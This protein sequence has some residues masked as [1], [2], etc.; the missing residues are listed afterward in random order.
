MGSLL[1]TI[2]NYKK[3]PM[4][5]VKGPLITLILSVAPIVYELRF[6]VILEVDVAKSQA[7]SA[8]FEITTGFSRSYI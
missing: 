5:N 7:L 3:D 6:H 2:L 8:F 1:G 4:S